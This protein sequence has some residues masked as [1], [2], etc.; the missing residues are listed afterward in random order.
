L[1][2]ILLQASIIS[3]LKVPF[4]SERPKWL[5]CT[6]HDAPRIIMDDTDDST[7]SYGAKVMKKVAR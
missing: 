2:T 6:V 3:Q 7:V 4:P 5:N 1:P